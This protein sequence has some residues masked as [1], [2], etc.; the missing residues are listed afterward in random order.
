VNLNF[1][2]KHP[3]IA[4]AYVRAV[5]TVNRKMYSDPSFL[6]AAIVQHLQFTPAQAKVAADAYLG[7]G[8]WDANGGLSTQALQETLDF[9]KQQNKLPATLKP[10][11]VADL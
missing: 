8:L 9:Y 1:A 2:A 5:V 4:Q 6:Q 7:A 3:D 11:D 10:E